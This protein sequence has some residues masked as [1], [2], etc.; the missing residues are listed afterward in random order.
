MTHTNKIKKTEKKKKMMMVNEGV[1]SLSYME[2]EC[3]SIKGLQYLD[4]SM[5]DREIELDI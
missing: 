1:S 2:V 4:R 3:R 5:I